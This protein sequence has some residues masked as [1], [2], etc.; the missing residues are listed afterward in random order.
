ME[1]TLAGKSGQIIKMV[2]DGGDSSFSLVSQTQ[3]TISLV[4]NV[5]TSIHLHSGGKCGNIF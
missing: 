2:L 1:L 3:Q 5:D 4:A